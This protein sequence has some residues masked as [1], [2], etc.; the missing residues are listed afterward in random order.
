MLGEA[1]RVLNSMSEDEMNQLMRRYSAAAKSGKKIGGQGEMR[2]NQSGTMVNRAEEQ[3]EKRL[4]EMANMAV[5]NT[6][7]ALMKM[8][9]NNEKQLDIMNKMLSEL[10][11]M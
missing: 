2:V 3:E 6:A 8:S 1:N 4:D 7:D 5:D 9:A 10:Q 11:A